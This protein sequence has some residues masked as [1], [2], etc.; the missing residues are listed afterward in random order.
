MIRFSSLEEAM[1]K[2]FEPF[3]FMGTHWLVRACTDQGW[4]LAIAREE[5][6]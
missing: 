2:G 3:N 4:V 1:K 5:G 6:K